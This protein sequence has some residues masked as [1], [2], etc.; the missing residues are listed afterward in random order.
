MRLDETDH[1]VDRKRRATGENSQS[2]GHWL[3]NSKSG[4]DPIGFFM[5]LWLRVECTPYDIA[6]VT[7]AERVGCWPFGPKC[8]IILVDH[9]D[10]QVQT[11]TYAR[12]Y[13][14]EEILSQVPLQ[15]ECLPQTCIIP[16]TS[17]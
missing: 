4:C 17:P 13:R 16:L 3:V 15:N 14:R 9:E 5:S 11:A 7:A 12:E 6:G 1:V 8:R 2:K 10:G